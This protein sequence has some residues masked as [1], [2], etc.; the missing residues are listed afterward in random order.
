MKKYSAMNAH[1][2]A[3][4][5][6]IKE[7]FNYNVGGWYNCYQDG[8]EDE[9]PTLQEAMDLVYEEAMST[10]PK[11][12]RFATESF[13]R[14]VVEKLFRTDVD[15]QE[16][17]GGN[18]IIDTHHNN[19][20]KTKED[21]N[22]TKKNNDYTTWTVKE[23]RAEAKKIGLTGA[24]RMKKEDLCAALMNTPEKTVQISKVNMF[25]FTGMFLGEFEAEVHDD[26]IL[27]NTTSKGELM[28]DLKTGKEITDPNKARYANRVE[29]V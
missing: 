20:E 3:A 16:L 27:V 26:K 24:S 10:H 9:I 1:E 23:L 6:A 14:E 8:Y 19:T 21:K 7:E 18:N 28:F 11:E 12:I 22:M 5:R 29:A 4:Y 25:A 13:C 15:A 17:W 2:K